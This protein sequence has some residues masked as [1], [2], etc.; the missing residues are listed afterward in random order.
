[1]DGKNIYC[2]KSLLARKKGPSMRPKTAWTGMDG[3]HQRKL[4]LLF[5]ALNDTFFESKLLIARAQ[6][7]C[8]SRCPATVPAAAEITLPRNASR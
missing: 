5:E 3:L 4:E 7:G 2:R 6:T 8:L 1:M